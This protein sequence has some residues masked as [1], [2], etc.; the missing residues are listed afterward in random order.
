[1]LTDIGEGIAQVEVLEWKVNVGDTVEEFQILCEVQSDK[2]NVEMP[3]KYPGI[4]RK[5]GAELG[6]M[7][8]T[9]KTLVH[10]EV[11]DGFAVTDKVVGAAAAPAPTPQA[12][13]TPDA[14]P[15]TSAAPQTTTAAPTG[16]AGGKVNATPAVRNFAK[17]KGVDL[18]M[19]TPTGKGGRVLKEDVMA[20]LSGGAPASAPSTG[21]SAPPSVAAAQTTAALASDQVVKITGVKRIMVKK[22]QEALHVPAFSYGDEINM[23]ALVDARKRLKPIAEKAGVKLSYMPFITKACSLA[24]TEFPYMNAHVN[25]DCSETILRAAHNIGIAVD[26]PAGLIVP[27]VKNC[28]QKSVLQI[29]KDINEL[30]DLTRSGK[31]SNEQLDGGTF[32]LSNIGAIGGTYVGPVIFCPQVAIS[33]LGA[34]QRLPR[35][36]GNSDNVIAQHIMAFSMTAD[37]R[38][39]DGAS[40]ARFA[41]RWK[42]YLENPDLMLL[43]MS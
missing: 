10:I 38:V 14:A 37:H 17:D 25:A 36:D 24:L 19:V 27:N 40:A 7:M 3:S 32:T 31:I 1:M 43:A 33:A 20:F 13:P 34:I 2:A 22:M 21:A 12:A 28:E 35:F 42:E 26:S 15:A 39:V 41:A 16:S 30:A 18:S 5:L 6:A 4:I 29:A 8:E 11:P 23:S 9:G